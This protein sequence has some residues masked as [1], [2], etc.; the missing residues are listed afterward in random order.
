MSYVVS[1]YSVETRHHLVSEKANFVYSRWNNGT[2]CRHGINVWQFALHACM[3]NLS[4]QMF[5]LSC[6]RREG[7]GGIGEVHMVV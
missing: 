5:I 6:K 1:L 2:R 4:P 7:G 3:G